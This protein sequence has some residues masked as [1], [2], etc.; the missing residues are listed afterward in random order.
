MN[1]HEF[2]KA[3]A[4]GATKLGESEKYNHKTRVTIP[5]TESVLESASTVIREELTQN[6]N[7][8]LRVPYFG[9]FKTVVKPEEKNKEMRNIRTGEKFF[10]D[11]P[12]KTLL[13]FKASKDVFNEYN[14]N[15]KDK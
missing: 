3:V 2:L 5:V 13:K 12:E 15:L 9:T 10:K 1:K 8:G 7:Q 14:P 4:T 11:V 6:N